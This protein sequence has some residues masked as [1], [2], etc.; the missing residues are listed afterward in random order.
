MKARGTFSKSLRGGGEVRRGPL[1]RVEL[2]VLL[3]GLFATNAIF[4]PAAFRSGDTVNPTRAGELGSFVGGY[5]GTLLTL[6][7]VLLLLRTL[8]E[9][10]RAGQQQAFETKYFTLLRLHRENVRE[11][12]LADASGRKVFVLIVRE[13]RALVPIVKRVAESVGVELTWRDVVAV[14]YYTLYFGTG[15]TSTPMLR[16]ELKAFGAA[17]TNALEAALDELTKREVRAMLKLPYQPFEGHQSRMGHY[18]R[19]LFQ[20]IRYID[21]QEATLDRYE[22]AKTIRA[23]LSA[24]EQA[25][26]LLN[27]MT[28]LGSAWWER[29]LLQNY[30]MV[31]NIPRGFFAEGEFP[32]EQLFPPDYFEANTRELLRHGGARREVVA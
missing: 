11:I 18:Y 4:V 8:A 5:V 6:V 14:A 7:T 13:W 27:T 10:R 25:L 28:P 26:L 29:G 17:F 31:S 22:Y 1:T 30:K 2:A 16:D 9:Q 3:L 12:T 15:P 23:Q 32:V 21:E 19:H 20:T 24:H